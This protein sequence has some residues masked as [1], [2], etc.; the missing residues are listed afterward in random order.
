MKTIITRRSLLAAAAMS[1]IAVPSAVEGS[2]Y[3]RRRRRE[4]LRKEREERDNQW[5]IDSLERERNILLE[6]KHA[7]FAEKQAHHARL[8]EI[9]GELRWRRSRSFY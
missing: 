3:T 1:L 7:T 2:S 9:E 4:R 5:Q 8:A 6:H